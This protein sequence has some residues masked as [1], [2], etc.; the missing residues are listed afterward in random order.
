MRACDRP[1]PE[2]ANRPRWRGDSKADTETFPIAEEVS[3]LFYEGEANSGRERWAFAFSAKESWKQKARDDV[4]GLIET[5]RAY[6]RIIFVTSRF[7]KA[8]D[9]AALE[10]VL[11]TEAGIPVTVHDRTWIVSEI[12]EKGRKDL[13]FNYLGVGTEVSDASKLGPTDYSRQQQLDET[14]R[15]LDNPDGHQE[16]E[17]H[18]VVDALLAAKLSRGLEQ[19]RVNVDG[20]FE[21][22]VRLADKYGFLHQRIEARYEHIWTAYWWFDDF[23]SLDTRY[24]A[25]E[26][27]A[28]DAGHARTLSLLVNLTQLLFNSVL[29]GH[30]GRTGCQLDP[31]IA[32]VRVLLAPMAANAERPNNR[33]EAASLLLHLDMNEAIP[34]RRQAGAYPGLAGLFGY[35]GPGRW[36]G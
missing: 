28:A 26:T 25:I 17:Q 23:E 9:R 22:A 29:H 34:C 33:L 31:R 2:A 6:N 1:Q 27:L 3:E 4:K 14:E 20:R 13:A 35:S 8:R 10:G 15:A 21:R 16:V 24:G 18:R 32:R 5:G 30:L 11:S 12:I 19:P 36:L 7:A